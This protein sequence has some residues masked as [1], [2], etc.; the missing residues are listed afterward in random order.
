MT[1][2]VFS[3]NITPLAL[4]LIRRR[5][6]WLE[7]GDELLKYMERVFKKVLKVLKFTFKLPANTLEK[8]CV[9]LALISF[10]FLSVLLMFF[11]YLTRLNNYC[12]I[13]K[14][15]WD[16]VKMEVLLSTWSLMFLLFCRSLS[17]H[18]CGITLSSQSAASR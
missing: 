5:S 17:S 3:Q 13:M 16:S 6:N 4:A 11:F 1:F 18:H 14:F 2:W 12:W 7:I 10:C 8:I 9:I 15:L